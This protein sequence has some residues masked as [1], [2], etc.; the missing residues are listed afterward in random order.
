PMKRYHWKVLPQGMKNSPTICQS[1]VASLLSPIRRDGGNAIIYHYMDDILICAPKQEQVQRLL[2]RI[3]TTLQAKGFEFRPEKIQRMPPWR[4]LGLEITKRTVRPQRLVIKDNPK[5]LAD[6]QQLCGTLNWVRPWLGITTEDL[7]PLFKLLEGGD[8]ITASRSLTPEAKTALK[9][10]ENKLSVRQANRVVPGLPFQFI[11]RGKLPHLHGL[12]YQWDESQRKGNSLIIIEWV[13][14][15]NKRSKTLTQPP[16]LVAELVRKARTRLRELA[17]EMFDYLIQNCEA[18]ELALEGFTGK[19]AH[20]CPSHQLFNLEWKLDCEPKLSRKP[21]KALTLFTDAS[22]SS[23][24][25]VITWVNPETQQWESDIAEVEGSPQVAELHAVVRAFEKF[26]EPFNLVTDSAYVAGVAQRAENAVLGDTPNPKIHALIS[27]LTYL[28]SRRDQPYYVMH[29]RSHTG[30][31][32]FLSEGNCRADELAAPTELALCTVPDKFHQAQRS[33]QMFHNNAPGLVRQFGITRQQAKAIVAACPN[34]QSFAVPSL[35]MGVN[36]RGLHSCE[37]WQTDVTHVSEF[38]R[39]KYVHVSIDTF[40]K[41]VFAS[42]HT[43][44]KAADVKKHLI[45][46]FAVL[47][48][49]KCLKTDNGPAYAS[50]ELREFLGLWGIEHKTGIPHSPTGQAIVE[51]SHATL[52]SVLQR[53]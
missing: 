23:H 49:P 8:D 50:R 2:D 43:G 26:S 33:H 3:I 6:L 44:E 42:A 9:I 19:I 31:P 37:V 39:Q 47:G 12:I 4:Y 30:L 1:Y 18:L 15:A 40:S 21:L 32:G 27:K 10:I 13:F 48:T 11:I 22:G 28:V 14:L 38:G 20:H 7:A 46:A 41:A 52:K 25:S 45:Q 36:P 5:T 24:K 34:C 17:A 29:I 16:E 53:Q 51:R 35:G